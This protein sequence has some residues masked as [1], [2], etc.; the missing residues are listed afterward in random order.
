MRSD[1]RLASSPVA[2]DD[3]QEERDEEVKRGKKETQHTLSKSNSNAKCTELMLEVWGNRL[4]IADY[5]L[6]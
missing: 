2:G 4:G 5:V 3:E 1:P 6:L